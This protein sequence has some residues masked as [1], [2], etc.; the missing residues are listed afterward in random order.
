MKPFRKDSKITSSNVGLSL[1]AIIIAGLVTF[2]SVNTNSDLLSS[3]AVSVKASADKLAAPTNLT[4]KN[5]R[6]GETDLSWSASTSSITTGYKILRS[7]TAYGPWTTIGSTNSPTAVTYIDKTSGAKKWNYRV[8]SV[9]S[10]WMSEGPAFAAPPAVGL[11]F[12]DT[13]TV[14]GS[15]D[16]RTTSDGSSTWQV[17]N[18]TVIVGEYPSWGVGAQGTGY[19]ALPATA[20][21]RT[22][23]NNAT[24]WGSDLDGH[25]G[26]VIRG[27]DPLNYIHVGGKP[28]AAR[29]DGSFQIATVSNGVRTI[30]LDKPMGGGEKN[31]RVEVQGNNIK[32]YINATRG[33]NTQGTL[34]ADVNTSFLATDPAATYFGIA[35]TGDYLIR[36]FYFDAIV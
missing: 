14:F 4:I 34:H 21:V 26:F 22:P 19:G 1:S 36:G 16:K 6:V 20:V 13:L 27:K 2:P 9:F 8:E 25:E 7:E 33:V 35:F 18:G 24:V 29:D 3:A 5:V 28:G 23:A 11:S 30:L 31:V 32:A 15:L 17:W 12:H 10:N